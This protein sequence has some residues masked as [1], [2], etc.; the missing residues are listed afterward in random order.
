MESVS[1][2]YLCVSTGLVGGVREQPQRKAK[3]NIVLLYVL[4]KNHDKPGNFTS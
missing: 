1:F 2:K 3:I 4:L